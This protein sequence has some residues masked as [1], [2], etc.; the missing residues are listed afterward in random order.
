MAAFRSHEGQHGLKLPQ[1]QGF[2]G[3]VQPDGDG[4]GDGDVGDG[5]DIEACLQSQAFPHS[6]K[7]NWFWNKTLKQFDA[8]S[9][10]QQWQVI[11]MAQLETK[12]CED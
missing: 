8:L 9:H 7:G 1:P 11:A 12:Y 2:N 4:E 5:G 6:L 3:S 10:Y